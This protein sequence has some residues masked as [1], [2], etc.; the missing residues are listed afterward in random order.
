MGLSGVRG[1]EIVGFRAEALGRNCGARYLEMD[2]GNADL[3]NS[4]SEKARQRLWI[5][6]VLQVALQALCALYDSVAQFRRKNARMCQNPKGKGGK[7]ANCVPSGMTAS[8]N[9][10]SEHVSL[11]AADG[12]RVPWFSSVNRVSHSLVLH[13]RL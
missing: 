13:Y 7:R 6:P 1:L 12:S 11:L 2:G 9:K 4:L 3:D 8:Q 5:G 10:S